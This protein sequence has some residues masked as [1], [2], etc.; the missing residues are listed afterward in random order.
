[1][2]CIPQDNLQNSLWTSESSWQVCLQDIHIRRPAYTIRTAGHSAVSYCRTHFLQSSS[3]MRAH[4]VHVFCFPGGHALWSA[5][6]HL[7]FLH[8]LSHFFWAQV[9]MTC[10]R[11][12]FGHAS[13][14]LQFQTETPLD[15]AHRQYKFFPRSA[16]SDTRFGC[17]RDRT[18]NQGLSPL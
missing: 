14:K 6:H 4:R 12:F 16:S 1:M 5:L 3:P 7:I 15:T 9:L 13:L 8:P 11:F 2:R 10:L 18:R 17:F